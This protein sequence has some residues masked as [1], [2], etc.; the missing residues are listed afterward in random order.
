MKCVRLTLR[1]PP[2]QRLDMSVLDV[3]MLAALSIDEIRAIELR[4]GR[5]TAPLDSIF[6]I[7]VSGDGSVRLEI[8]NSDAHLDGVGHRLKTGTVVVYGDAGRF[9]GLEM[10]GGDIHVH[11]SCGDWAGAE[12]TA[13]K[14]CIDANV[15]AFAGS[16]RAGERRGMRG[17]AIVIRGNA[18]DRVGDRMRRGIIVV[19]GNT[20]SHCASRMIAGTIAVAG[21]IG[22]S[23]GLGMRRGTLL[24]AQEPAS[25][26]CTFNSGGLQEMNFLRLMVPAIDALDSD[27]VWP[28]AQRTRVQRWVGDLAWNGYGEI[29]LPA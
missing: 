15:G 10:G 14:I 23:A 12:M 9:L 24:L 20:G 11:G 29:I 8:Y 19:Q 7:A 13:G 5:A 17:G 22:P 21:Q 27:Y 25:L 28:C 1:S 2:A 16:A 3:D 6:D 26:P 4:C 18:G